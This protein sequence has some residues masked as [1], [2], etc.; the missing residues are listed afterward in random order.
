MAALIG[1][2]KT[3][4]TTKINNSDNEM[5]PLFW[6]K[7]KLTVTKRLDLTMMTKNLKM[8]GIA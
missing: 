7:K 6:M 4:K 2:K 8:N 5:M 1:N 3:K